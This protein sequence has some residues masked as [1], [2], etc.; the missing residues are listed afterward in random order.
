MKALIYGMIVSM[1]VPLAAGADQMDW[2]GRGGWQPGRGSV[3][4]DVQLDLP[5]DQFYFGNGN[6]KYV[7][8][9]RVCDVSHIRIIVTGDNIRINDFDIL[10][11][12]GQTQDIPLREKFRRD[13]TSAW[14]DLRGQV[15]CI[16][17]FSVRATPDFDWNN[18]RIHVIGL[19]QTGWGPRQVELGSIK[20]RDFQF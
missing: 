1:L 16:Q 2:R 20:I 15:R 7:T 3:I 5:A 9:R 11:G 17:G 8:I 13:S 4:D 19:Q 18:A 12:N 6:T 10:F 14:K